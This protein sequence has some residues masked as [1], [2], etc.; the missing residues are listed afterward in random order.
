MQGVNMK[1]KKADINKSKQ[2]DTKDLI[3][4]I[5]MIALT[6]YGVVSLKEHS[7]LFVNK[8]TTQTKDAILVSKRIDN[9]YKIKLYVSLMTGVKITEVLSEMQKRIKYEVENRFHINVDT[10]D[11]YVQTMVH[12]K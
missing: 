6:C 1:Q 8:K 10:V 2:I 4:A 9:S 11:V 12:E 5:E 3:K 7:L